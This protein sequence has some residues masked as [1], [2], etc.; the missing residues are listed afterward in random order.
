ME[1]IEG[2]PVCLHS[3]R[4]GWPMRST[5]LIVA[6]VK[7]GVSIPDAALRHEDWCKGVISRGDM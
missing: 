3:R 4:D 6:W 7:T 2:Y 5:K 1:F